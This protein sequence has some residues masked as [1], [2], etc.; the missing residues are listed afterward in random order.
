MMVESVDRLFWETRAPSTRKGKAGTFGHRL[1]V[2][3]QVQLNE[4]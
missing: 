2:A 3:F 4:E 1:F